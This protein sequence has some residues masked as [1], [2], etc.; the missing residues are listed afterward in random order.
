MHNHEWVA[1]LRETMALTDEVLGEVLAAGGA[2]AT[3]EDVAAFADV[4]LSD[5]QS[6]ALLDGL[7]AWRRGPSPP[8]PGT[9]P[10]VSGNLVLKKLRIAL[11]LQEPDLVKLFA[12]GGLQVGPRAVRPWF[13]RASSKHYK[14][15]DDEVLT[16][17]FAG[18]ASLGAPPGPLT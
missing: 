7:I 8:R 2:P 17:F 4:P 14:R 1:R 13:R 16:A 12:A 9:P 15:V 6:R 18:L 3:P 11:D 10:D 5:D